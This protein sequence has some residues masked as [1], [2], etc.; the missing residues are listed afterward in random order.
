MWSSM[1]SLSDFDIAQV[2]ESELDPAMLKIVKKMSRLLGNDDLRKE[3]HLS[4]SL[5]PPNHQTPIS[6]SSATGCPTCPSTACPPGHNNNDNDFVDA[7][8]GQNEF[9]S[10]GKMAE[11]A[12]K[13]HGYPNDHNE[14]VTLPEN[15][16]EDLS[17]FS[18]ADPC[19]HSSL[20]EQSMSQYAVP[21]MQSRKFMHSRNFSRS[22]PHQ[23]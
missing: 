11:V 10:A 12:K 19:K 17:G 15:G 14:R 13:D 22:V 18:Q 21:P 16:P 8:Q 20:P 23:I 3:C 9:T 7:P 6:L 2:Q 5:T 4:F 1:I